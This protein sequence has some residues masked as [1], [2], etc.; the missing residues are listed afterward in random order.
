[1]SDML[2]TAYGATATFRPSAESSSTSNEW[3]MFDF[4]L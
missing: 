1:M 3:Q 4:I 2:T